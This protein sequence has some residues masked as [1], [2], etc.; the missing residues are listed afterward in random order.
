MCV[1][2]YVR[3]RVCLCL[4]LFLCMCLCLCF[5]LCLCE[6]AHARVCPYMCHDPSICAPPCFPWH[7]ALWQGQACCRRLLHLLLPSPALAQADAGEDK[8]G[9][10][11]GGVLEDLLRLLKRC[12][13]ESGD[14]AAHST[15][16]AHSN[17]LGGLTT[18][19]HDMR[20]GCVAEAK[21]EDR[22]EGL[23][24]EDGLAAHG[25]QSL[26]NK[27]RGGVTCAHHVRAGFVAETSTENRGEGGGLRHL[28]QDA[29]S[30]LS[31][32]V[33]LC[34]QSPPRSSLYSHRLAMLVAMLA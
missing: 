21:T 26:H 13:A 3:V 30:N 4:C 19:S 33:F 7:A 6:R 17:S 22:E 8:V 34:F 20:A 27:S 24:A 31:G 23:A 18:C 15:R 12:D 11:C 5:C 1:C 2:V 25:T 32:V 10:W 9:L 16:A 28:L 14:S 29:L